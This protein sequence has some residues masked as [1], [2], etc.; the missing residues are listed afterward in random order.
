MLWEHQT[1]SWV[2][3]A[4]MESNVPNGCKLMYCGGSWWSSGITQ[5]RGSGEVGAARGGDEQVV[6]WWRRT[7]DGKVVLGTVVLA[8]R[9]VKAEVNT[10]GRHSSVRNIYC[11]VMAIRL[12]LLQWN[13][14]LLPV[15]ALVPYWD[16][17]ALTKD[18]LVC[19]TGTSVSATGNVSVNVCR[20]NGRTGHQ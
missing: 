19:W 17:S 10:C 1:A 11:V 7:G 16:F 2:Q 9:T 12:Y 14:Y 6:E 15:F 20:E 8:K 18:Q 5:K 4:D 3:K 13:L